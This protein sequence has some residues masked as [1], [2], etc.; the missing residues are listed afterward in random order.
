MYFNDGWH[1][2]AGLVMFVFMAGFWVALA[3]IIGSVV[4]RGGPTEP[5]HSEAQRILDQRFARG[6]VDQDEYERRSATLRNNSLVTHHNS[7]EH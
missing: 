3:V 5:P 7:R 1:W 6:E 2:G 4:T